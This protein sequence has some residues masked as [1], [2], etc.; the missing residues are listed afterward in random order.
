LTLRSQITLSAL[1]LLLATGCTV[2]EPSRSQGPQQPTDSL[3]TSGMEETHP[4]VRGLEGLT[5]DVYYEQP[6]QLPEP[7]AS[8]ILAIGP[9]SLFLGGPKKTDLS[10]QATLP[11]QLVSGDSLARE[12]YVAPERNTGFLVVDLATGSAR[13]TGAFPPDTSKTENVVPATGRSAPLPKDFGTTPDPKPSPPGEPPPPP[14]APDFI[15]Q[16]WIDARAIEAV[17]WSPGRYAIRVIELERTSNMVVA[18]LVDP[19]STNTPPGFPADVAVELEADARR[20]NSEP[21]GSRAFTRGAET[22]VL[23]GPGAAFSMDSKIS[24]KGGPIEFRGT[25]RFPLGASMLVDPKSFAEQEPEPPILEADLPQAIVPVSILVTEVGRMPPRLHEVRVPYST[26]GEL[27]AGDEVDVAF[28]LDLNEVA[29][30]FGR[31]TYFVYLVAGEHIAGPQ[32]VDCVP[33]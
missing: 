13:C 15:E 9:G 8:A 4:V 33:E 11:L 10:V 14:V 32:R 21:D 19:K 30:P 22:P 24:I 25:A 18:T 20:A 3:R 28:A 2:Q 7:L 16:A 5:D 1:T 23:S 12:K 27:R 6:D 31:G 29:G 17:A 26:G